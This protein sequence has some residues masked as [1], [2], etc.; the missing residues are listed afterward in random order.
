MVREPAAPAI[1]LVEDEESMAAGIEFNLR[2]E[3]YTVIRARD[4]RE[5][6]RRFRDAAASLVILDIMIPY[7]DGFEVAG[8]IREMDPQIPIL[9]L[10]ARTAPADRVRGLESGADDYMT[11]PFHLKELLLR[12]SGMLKRKS[13]Y[14]RFL[15]DTIVYTFGRN[16]VNFADLRC[17]SGKK[18]IRLTPLEAALLRYFVGNRGKVI[19]R[20]ELLENVW[21]VDTGVETRTV[22]NFVHRLRRYFELDPSDPRY[23]RSVRGAGYV[24]TPDG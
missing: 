17:T 13:W 3:G 10:T 6:I 8:A 23:L 22:D 9:M 18:E 21:N 5:A 19:S 1:L 11:K 12:I 24:F 20:G 2:E 16:T 14:R 15:P 7:M 4:G